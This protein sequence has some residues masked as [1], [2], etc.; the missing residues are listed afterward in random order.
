MLHHRTETVAIGRDIGRVVVA[1]P[2]GD[3]VVRRGQGGGRIA[4][5]RRVFFVVVHHPVHGP[6]ADPERR[7]KRIGRLAWEAFGDAVAVLFVAAL[8]VVHA[9][10]EV[11]GTAVLGEQRRA[12]QQ[13][14]QQQPVQE[15]GFHR[16]F[17]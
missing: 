5:G 9:H 4:V 16:S 10:G 14:Q 15:T 2:P 1:G 6:I 13:D 17:L 3:G 8:G 12:E 7:E 11:H